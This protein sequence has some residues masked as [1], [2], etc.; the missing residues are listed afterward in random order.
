MRAADVMP[1]SHKKL[2]I[3]LPPAVDTVVI[4]IRWRLLK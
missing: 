3:V 2:R 1:N 4:L